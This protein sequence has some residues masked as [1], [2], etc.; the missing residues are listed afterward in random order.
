M[1]MDDIFLWL[2]LG[3]GALF[4]V[5]LILHLRNNAKMVS[6]SAEN[7]KLEQQLF[8]FKKH[9]MQLQGSVD[10]LNSGARGMGEKVHKLVDEL[11]DVRA[12]QE[13]LK[14]MEPEN[15]L[16]SQASKMASQGAS[17]EELIEDC[18]LPR[19]E[20]ELLISLHKKTENPT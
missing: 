4:V 16:Y 12:Q 13:L 8:L 11:S 1:Q 3:N 20:A 14:N 17:V 19:A 10:E 15:R 5:L 2:G 6:L 9:M 18:D 7:E